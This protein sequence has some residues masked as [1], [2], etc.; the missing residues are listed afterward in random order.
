MK[1]RGEFIKVRRKHFPIVYDFLQQLWEGKEIDK[2]RTKKYFL[3][4]LRSPRYKIFLMKLDGEIVGYTSYKYEKDY[5]FGLICYV[6]EIVVN[7]KLRGKGIGSMIVKFLEKTNKEKCNMI[8]LH[9]D[10]VRKKTRNFYK[11]K[12]FKDT[13][14]V[15]EKKLK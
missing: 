11:K 8:R 3:Y 12:R 2:K 7:K 1:E 14:V 4:R 6:D 9:T 13:G 10:L 5:E 15:F